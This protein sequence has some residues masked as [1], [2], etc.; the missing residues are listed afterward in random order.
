M[1]G[2]LF[3][4]PIYFLKICIFVLDNIGQRTYI[5]THIS[6]LTCTWLTQYLS[7]KYSSK[8]WKTLHAQ[9]YI[10]SIKIF[11]YWSRQEAAH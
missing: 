5:Y 6:S 3:Q 10:T 8:K 2:T 11:R 9:C 7:G 1:H 4:E